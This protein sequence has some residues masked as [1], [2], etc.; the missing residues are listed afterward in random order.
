MSREYK[1]ILC[2]K[3]YYIREFVLVIINATLFLSSV[4]YEVFLLVSVILQAGCNEIESNIVN[5][6]MCLVARRVR[7]KKGES[8]NINEKIVETDMDVWY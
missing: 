2:T 7:K 5:C 3:Y 1:L 4:G 8:K 6:R